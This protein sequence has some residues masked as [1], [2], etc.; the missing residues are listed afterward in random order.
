VSG[1]D[2]SPEHGVLLHVVMALCLAAYQGHLQD[3]E[4]SMQAQ[5]NE[6]LALRPAVA[7]VPDGP[8]SGS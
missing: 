5:S 7:T 8:G 2:Y 1:F 4:T 6:H 3:L